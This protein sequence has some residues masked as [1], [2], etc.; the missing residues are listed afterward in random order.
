MRA[1]NAL[2]TL[3][4]HGG[5]QVDSASVTVGQTREEA[6]SSRH[7]C[8][9]VDYV[10]IRCTLGFRVTP[11]ALSVRLP[12]HRS[13]A[14]RTPG[15]LATAT[16]CPGR[17][18]RVGP[19]PGDSLRGLSLPGRQLAGPGPFP[20]ASLKGPRPYRAGACVSHPSGRAPLVLLGPCD[21]CHKREIS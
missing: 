20:G 1:G 11:D 12:W 17:G 4:P 13:S 15:P 5:T 6:W 7:L 21:R 19:T 18:E 10:P 9:D 2:S 16:A 3:G 14:P 8:D